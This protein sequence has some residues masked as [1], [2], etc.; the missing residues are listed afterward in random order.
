M[1]R[2]RK[3]GNPYI[4]TEDPRLP[5]WRWEVL[6][7]YKADPSGDLYARVFVFVTSPMTGPSGDLGD[8]YVREIG[9]RIVAFDST[10]FATQELAHRALFGPDA[11]D[12]EADRMR[13][14]GRDVEVIRL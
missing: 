9:R 8:S 14:A 10:V 3:P 2:S 5:G 1:G 4:V 7:A 12:R 11:L 6:K 13:A